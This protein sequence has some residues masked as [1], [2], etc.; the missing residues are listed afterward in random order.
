[1]KLSRKPSELSFNPNAIITNP[2]ILGRKVKVLDDEEGYVDK[3]EFSD[4]G[5]FSKPIFGD[6]ENTEYDYSCKCGNLKGKFYEGVVCEKCGTPVQFVE[7]NIDKTGWID[8]TG[9]KY[10]EDGAVV[11]KGKDYKVV[12]YVAYE[13][14]EKIIGRDNMKNILFV[15]DTITEKG[16]L[17]EDAIAAVRA[18]SPEKKYWYLGIL[19]FSKNYKEVLDYYYNLHKINDQELYDFVSNPFDTFTDKIPVISAILRPAMRTADGLKLDEINNI[20][21][22]ILKSVKILTS[23]TDLLPIVVN[24]TLGMI[25]AEYFTLNEYALDYIR[26]KEGLIRNQICGVRLNY[27]A[28]SII[29]PAFAGRK[30]DEIVVP[31]KTF[32]ELYKFEIIN[33]IKNVKKVSFK[34]A[35]TIHFNAGLKFDEEVYLIMKDLI[36]H[37]EVGVLLNRN[38]TIN[39]GS[40]LYL[41]I[42][43][44]KHN[45]DDLTMSVNNCILTLL[46]GDYDGDTLNLISIK[47]VETRD[48]FKSIFS[49][50]H[51]MIDPKN[52]KFNNDLNLERDQVLGLN[53]LLS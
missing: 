2:E 43:D 4:D 25:Q 35:E 16:N 53:A 21:I 17:D 47:D 33:V 30:I 24:S 11:E 6:T 12:K 50:I 29:S 7:P 31:Y 26:S 52:G 41:R 39:I 1:M 14:L 27:T 5:L 13:F 48:L 40:I 32:L 8:L 37:N 44:I 9:A 36:D 34:E 20:Y 38:P 3:K 18:E 10:S 51:L 19:E 46:A 15:P 23:K 49:P 45:I 42:T 22:R 28:R